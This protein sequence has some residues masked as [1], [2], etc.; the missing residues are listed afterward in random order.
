M[1]YAIL[2]GLICI[3]CLWTVSCN[4]PVASG[5]ELNALPQQ[6]E[7]E[8][9]LSEL[10]T[11]AGIAGIS[12]SVIQGDERADY[13]VGLAELD[14]NTPMTTDHRMLLG[15]TGKTFVAAKALQMAAAG[16]LELD[17][18]AHS[19]LGEEEWFRA[20]PNWSSLTVRQLMNH[21]SGIPEY[22]YAP[23]LWQGLQVEPDRTYT[24]AERMAFIADAEPV[25]PAGGGWSYADAN[26]IILGAI[27]ESVTGTALYEQLEQAFIQPLGLR[28]TQPSICRLMDGLSAAYTGNF[29]ADLYGEQVAEL[30]EY[31]FNPQIEW[32]GGG[33]VTRPHD[34]A[35]WVKAL[36]TGDVIPKE[37]QSDMQTFINQ[38]T[39]EIDEWG[40]GLG[41][42]S[43]ATRY[44]TAL[45]HSGF[46]PGFQ[47]FMAYLP[48]HDFTI[49]FQMNTDPYHTTYLRGLRV[50]AIADQI[51]GLFLNESQ[52]VVQET[53][54]VYL[55][56]HAEKEEDG[57]SNPPLSPEGQLRADAYVLMLKEAE[58]AAV[59]VTPYQRTLQTAAPIA[60][61]YG[62]DVLS[63][64]PSDPGIILQ[65]LSQHPKGEIV[66]V[67]HSNT[68]PAMLN[69]L[70]RTQ[71][72]ETLPEDAY[73]QLFKVSYSPGNFQLDIQHMV[74]GVSIE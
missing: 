25:F 41:L 6:I 56:R 73:G 62:L 1:R 34:L 27:L 65:M 14:T 59:Y 57:T 55:L 33:W 71:D 61:S 26:Y 48:E 68:I 13:A 40:Y 74:E 15:S 66:V 31:A 18:L 29:F 28:A 52:E 69:F 5:Q 60:D 49:A 4:A 63:Y 45:G 50:E 67:G 10:I 38:E 51:M 16:E 8:T 12:V 39:A 2:Y 37:L 36:I 43:Y 70:S 11:T 22:V 21:S 19:Y 53:R 54:R 44:G 47:T 17:E 20:L 23:E 30:G 35:T 9:T 32:A 7:V 72:Y 24:V 42:I 3:S 64:S 46:M 58:I